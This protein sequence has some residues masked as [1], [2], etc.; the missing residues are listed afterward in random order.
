MVIRVVDNDSKYYEFIRLLRNDERVQSGFIQTKPISSE[1]QIKYME[2]Y[3]QMYIIAL[4]GEQPVGYAGSIDRDIRVCVHPDYQG[5]GVGSVLIDELMNRFPNSYAKIKI[6]NE[7]SK[8][9]F[10]KC[11]FKIKYVIMEKENET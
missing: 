7:S 1:D 6:E 8:R 4:D 3:H 11:G 2:V 5:M 10:S 9:M